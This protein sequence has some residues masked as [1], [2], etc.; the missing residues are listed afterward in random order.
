M[1]CRL[2]F[3]MVSVYVFCNVK[4]DVLFIIQYYFR[5]TSFF[6]G[7]KLRQKFLCDTGKFYFFFFYKIHCITNIV[8]QTSVH[9]DSYLCSTFYNTG[10]NTLRPL[11][12][13]NSLLNKHRYTQ[14]YAW[15]LNSKFYFTIL[16]SAVIRCLST[17]QLCS[18]TVS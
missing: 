14:A 8:S 2:A 13:C 10:I 16:G 11:R 9:F 4:S 15:M 18:F 3:I 6:K 5:L 1:I 7:D 17:T 12:W